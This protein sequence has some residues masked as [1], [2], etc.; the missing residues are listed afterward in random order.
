MKFR[1]WRRA[2]EDWED[3]WVIGWGV[4]IVTLLLGSYFRPSEGL[5]D[6]ARKEAEIRVAEIDAAEA[7]AAATV[8]DVE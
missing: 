3:I 7:V 1:V 8:E 5:L 6:W 4:C 2:W